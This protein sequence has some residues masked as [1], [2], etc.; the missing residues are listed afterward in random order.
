MAVS[1]ER[2]RDVI[3]RSGR[4]EDK[5]PSE[6]DTVRLVG[7][8][9]LSIAVAL[10][11]TGLLVE[12]VHHS[13][14]SVFH[15]MYS[16]SLGSAG[17]L[18]QTFNAAAP[19]LLIGLGSLISVRAGMFNIGQTG[20]LLVG[21]IAAGF[22]VLKIHGLPGPLLLILGLICAFVAG[23]VWAGVSALL[24]IKSNIDVVISTLLMGYVAAQLLTYVVSSQALLRQ[25]NLA[26]AGG[27]AQSAEVPANA[28]LPQTGQSP[29]FGV[30]AAV[31]IALVILAVLAILL[32]RSQWGIHLRMVGFNP[33]AAR[34][35]G[36]RV[37]TIAGGALI[38]SGALAALTGGIMLTSSAYGTFR[39][40]PGFDNN[41]G[42]D[43]LLAALVCRDRPLALI[44]VS[45]FFGA[46]INGGNFL[47]ATGV[48]NYLGQVL[49]S[50]LVLAAVFPPVFL[51]RKQWARRIRQSHNEL[52]LEAA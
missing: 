46:I 8:Y 25:P 33:V 48:P 41:F 11:I 4:D 52:L 22:I 12:L 27:L 45:F 39:I 5:P 10:V 20:Q 44:P 35:F 38:L 2:V 14:T 6:S 23:A 28:R 13:A 37:A 29:S 15:A 7:L 42:N 31:L 40:Q 34:R 51:E 16:G 24:K 47:L 26:A 17:A 1:V 50:L 19:V 30:S 3:R 18:G 49:Q 21:A 9:V 36:V 32:S 43:G